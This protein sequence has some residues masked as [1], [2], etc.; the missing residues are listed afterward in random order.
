MNP[1]QRL[2]TRIA[3]S[4]VICSAL[5][6]LGSLYNTA[7]IKGDSYSAKA[8]AQYSKPAA[9]LFD[10][11]TIFFSARSDSGS[12]KTAAAT[13]GRGSLVYINPKL[14]K[15]PA[16]T[17]EALTQ[18]MTLDKATF[19][20]K[21]SKKDDP[22]EE[23]AH[24]VDDTAAAAVRK[25]GLPAIGVVGETWRSYPGGVLA[26]HTLGIIG[27]D[28]VSSSVVGK[29]GL[30]RSYDEVLSRASKGGT[31]NIFARLFSDGSEPGTPGDPG[32]QGNILTTI[33]PT[34]ERYL[35]KIL[36]EVDAA[37][38]PDEVGG[39]IMDPVT[40]EIQAMA[41]LP[42]Y[43]PNNTLAAKNVSVFSNSLVEHVYEMGSIV[44]PLTMAM[45]L[46]AGVVT[47]QSTYNDVGCMTLD[48]KK[49][50]NYDGRARGVVPIQE[51]LSQ[52]LNIG[53]AT[54]ALRTGAAEF[55]RYF[56]S[57]GLADKTKIDLPNE[58][59][60]IASNLK[61]GKD[62]DVA[63]ASYGQGIAVSPLGMVRA[64]SI[65][66]NGGYLVTPH[67]VKEIE[68]L[69]GKTKVISP[70]RT[71]PVL[72]PQTVEDV[73]RM[74][75]TVVDKALRQGTIKREHY[76]VAA[77]TGTASIADP[78]KGGYYSD[79]YLHSFFGFFPAYN[80][81]FLVFLYQVH[82]KGAQFASETLTLPFDELTTFLLNYYNIP[83]DR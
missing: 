66:A 9:A 58:A 78:V 42:S 61:A 81:R 47:T 83:P 48:T 54:L 15:D 56:R 39:I 17:Y 18:Y 33:E 41:S 22:Y 2:R 63:T 19:M 35:E 72:K 6:L 82:P 70:V 5:V 67:V 4:A 43:D 64:L 62:I 30:E 24:K 59:N 1:R 8:E 46:D 76:T 71:G 11:G 45:A 36:G 44:K 65:L 23:L 68:Y 12:N 60:P 13:I 52:S 51:I 20:S 80:P 21:A 3:L 34:V 7:I 73:R 77:K 75:V 16:G 38:H 29:Y 79:R 53:V 32:K 10:R 50:C 37:W 27:E 57:F 49:I 40:G 55:E 28:T 25:L 31:A 26:A 74:L 14:L 69:D